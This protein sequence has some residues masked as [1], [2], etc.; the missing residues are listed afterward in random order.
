[1]ELRE[2]P[3]RPTLAQKLGDVTHISPLL[4]K[5]GELSGCAEEQTGDWLLRCA[6]ERGA[7]HYRRSFDQELPPD[8][9][10]LTN[11]E[12][13]VALCLPRHR[14]SPMLIR[15][16]AQLLSSPNTDAKALASLAVSEC[17]EPVLLHIAQAAGRVD[18]HREPW[19]YLRAQLVSRG[20]APTDELPHVPEIRELFL[21]A[22]PKV[23]K[24]A[25]RISS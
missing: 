9:P 15:A 20:E 8:N 24:L 17:C 4:R 7:S 5:V 18:S 23:L 11:E 6:V 12:L 10:R 22:Q 2:Q 1:M 14:S 21:A 25:S 19:A 13:G 3:A 16:A